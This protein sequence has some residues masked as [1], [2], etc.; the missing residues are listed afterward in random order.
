MEFIQK[1]IVTFLFV[2]FSACFGLTT[3]AQA[4][5][6]TAVP[7]KDVEVLIEPSA[8]EDV[9]LQ[10]LFLVDLAENETYNWH[11]SKDTTNFIIEEGYMHAGKQYKLY[12]IAVNDVN[13]PS[14]SSNEIHLEIEVFQLPGEKIP[15]KAK[16]PFPPGLVNR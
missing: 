3:E 15:P 9:V 11:L 7:Y 13:I 14:D 1:A 12:M 6:F 16:K 5:E 10:I 2:F 4:Q 8:S